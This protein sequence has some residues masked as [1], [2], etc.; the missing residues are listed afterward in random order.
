MNRQIC[1]S[2]RDRNKLNSNARIS[3][4]DVACGEAHLGR[5]PERVQ[6]GLRFIQSHRE[7][8]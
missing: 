1:L 5:E 4:L 6:G 8:V 2:Q 3:Y 7:N